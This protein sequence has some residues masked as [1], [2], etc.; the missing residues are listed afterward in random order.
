MCGNVVAVPGKGV[1]N[2]V[3][4]HA[5][6]RQAVASQL[7]LGPSQVRFPGRDRVDLAPQQSTH[8]CLRLQI[9]GRQRTGRQLLTVDERIEKE[10]RRR[11]E[12]H[13]DALTFQISRRAD[14]AV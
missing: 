3:D 12:R 10:V 8:A 9:D 11:A 1:G 14:A 7:Y 5:V 4:A 2:L 6:E 13:A